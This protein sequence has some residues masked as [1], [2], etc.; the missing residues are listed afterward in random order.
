IKYAEKAVELDPT[1]YELLRRLGVHMATQ[2][3]LPDAIRLLE[4]AVGSK[5]L[6]K[7]TPAYVTLNRDLAILYSAVGDLPKAADA[8][9]VVFDARRNPAA[10]GLEEDLRARQALEQDPT[11]S[12]ERIGQAFLDAERIELAVQAFELAAKEREG[13]P[14]SLNYN[15]ARVYLQTKEH[16]KALDELQKY[17]DAELQT[18]GRDAY[19]LLADILAAMDRSGDLIGRLKTLA[20][21]DAKNATLQY[22]LAEQY[23]EADRL[24][25]AEELFKKTLEAGGGTEGHVGLAAV[26]R[27]QKRPAELL[28]TLAAAAGDG[29]NPEQ[30]LRNLAR[31]ETEVE[32]INSDEKL[33]GDL[34]AEG[35]R[36]LAAG[37]AGLDFVPA[38]ILGQI[39]VA[40]DKTEDVTAFYRQALKSRPAAAAL[41]FEELGSHLFDVDDYAGA[42][43]VFEEAVNTPAAQSARPNF[44]FRLSQ[45][46]ALAGDTKGALEAVREAQNL[47]PNV[48]LLH[49]QEA[50]IYYHARE[51]DEATKRL[52]QVIAQFPQDQEIVRRCQFTLSNVYV[53]QGDMRKGEA[54]LEQVL[55]EDPDDPSVNNDLGYLYAD[56]GKNLEQAESMIR[57]AVEAEP[58][59][60]AYLDSMGWVLYKRGKFQDAAEWLEKAVKLPSGSDA[61][62]L[63]HLGDCYRQLDQM[64]K[65]VETWQKALESAKKASQPEKKII[66]RIEDKLQNAAAEPSG[67]KPAEP[68]SP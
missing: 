10:F 68:A 8:Y 63:D 12:Y 58:E 50:W 22:F 9:R 49:Y 30:S 62:I 7:K 46:R 38:M 39:A 52:E 26:Y 67:P 48:A 1:D 11:S 21:K 65:A 15:L 53:Q 23:L 66:E 45:A 18:K 54:I 41:V 6:D 35:R 40:A 51:W 56:Q 34:L 25:L 5:T 33:Q 3:N 57:K 20:E 55:V 61:T 47:L 43:K 44:L 42:A 14:G 4:K 60:A 59:N 2:R 64:P 19:Q 36:R 28:D 31:I 16:Q 29:R 13:K 17:F 27:R 24:D 37:G 32:A